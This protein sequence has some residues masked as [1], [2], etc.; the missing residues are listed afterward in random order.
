MNTSL[1][2]LTHEERAEYIQLLEQQRLLQARNSP[3][4]F[5]KQIFIPS[6]PINDDENCQE[7][8]QDKITPA[9]HHIIILNTIEKIIKGTL[10]DEDGKKIKSCI[11]LAPPGSAKST[12]ASLVIPTWYM[13]YK[14][15]SNMIMTTY[16][17]DLANKFGRKCRSICRSKEYQQIF[18]S[19]L[20]Q[21]NSA[22]NDWSTSNASTYMCGGIL[23]G[24]TG[25]RADGLIIDDPFKNREAA[26][27][28]T[29]RK[30]TKEEYKETLLSRLK[31][32]G[33]KMII[34]TR[35]HQD[36]LCGQILPDKYNGDSGIFKAED[37]ESWYVL[38]F[39]AEC[40]NKTDPLNRKIGDFLWL[41]WFNQE[42][43]EQTKRTQAGSTWSSLYQGVPTPEEGTFFKKE[44]FKRYRIG[45]EPE[46]LIKY[47]AGDYAVSDGQGDFT[48]IGAA[49]FDINE[50]LW[51]LDWWSGQTAP[52]KWID[53]LIILV[54]KI[55]PLVSVAEGGLIRRSIEPFLTKEMQKQKCY[56]RQEWI[57]SSANKKANARSFQ[58][59]ASQSKVWIP[60]G[61]WGDT[62]IDQLISFPSGKFD[63]KVD[64]CG[65]FG[66]ILDQT[67]AP[68]L[69]ELKKPVIM[70][71]YS[72]E[73]ESDND[74]LL[75]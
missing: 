13:G 48:E 7:F 24:I 72:D 33:W 58:G 52:D 9:D 8:Y 17:S 70:N 56:F 74:W 21:G 22:S 65:L 63:D 16:G 12:Y 27:S 44:W 1:N 31:P 71:D 75:N 20:V 23:S 54:K 59:L 55:N 6:A 5:A 14:P 68:T 69:D 25:N 51:M 73:E 37:G 46:R 42:W 53:Q 39:Q 26:D 36:D 43:W 19:E 60:Y 35:W 47:I 41:D 62:L 29:I 15:N 18:D 57:T 67:F 2:K 30:K 64:V 10:L 11:V 45:Q 38:N 32:N 28:E 34:N 3:L 66:R 40:Q 49:G 61:S 4:E 50:D